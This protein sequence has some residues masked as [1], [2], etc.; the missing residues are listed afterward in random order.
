MSVQFNPHSTYSVGM[1]QAWRTDNIE[2]D[3]LKG[4]V[5][6]S[7]ES[8]REQITTEPTL[9]RQQSRLVIS[10]DDKERVVSIQTSGSSSSVSSSIVSSASSSTTEQTT[11]TDLM[12]M[13]ST[14]NDKFDKLDT[15]LKIK[16]RQ[17]E[18]LVTMGCTDKLLSMVVCGHLKSVRDRGLTHKEKDS[19]D[20]SL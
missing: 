3:V 7:V 8:S 6:D 17:I 2:Q 11:L 14:L 1:A 13:M 4:A 10:P 18:N 9:I 19:L 15:R 12:R 20:D 5:M 16:D